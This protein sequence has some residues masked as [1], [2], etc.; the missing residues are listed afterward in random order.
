M[1]KFNDGIPPHVLHIHPDR[2]AAELIGQY[3]RKLRH[4]IVTDDDLVM[5]AMPRGLT[6]KRASHFPPLKGA[7]SPGRLQKI[8]RAMTPF[9]L[10]LSHGWDAMDAAMAHTLFKDAMQLPPLIHHEA[11]LGDAEEKRLSKRRTWYRRIALGKSSG[12]VIPSERLE[13]VALVD[14]QQPLGRVK[15]IAPGVDT[16]L[17]AKQPKPDGFRVIKRPGEFWLGTHVDHADAQ[18]LPMLVRTFSALDPDWHLVVLGEAADRAETEAAIDALE[19]NDRVHWAGTRAQP[20]KV[21]GLFD[22]FA[23]ARD[24]GRFPRAGVEAMAAGV[25]LV[26][27][28]EGELAHTVAEANHPYLFQKGDETALGEKLAS[29]ARDKTARANVGEANRAHAVARYDR[30]KTIAT[31]RRLYGSAMKIEL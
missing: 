28:D 26:V 25:A 10:V 22:I 14:W 3:G 17:F 21:M 9:D 30:N 19:L 7:P 29:L 4:T 15:R 2:D 13:E 12:L 8:A 23:V 20:E 27:P 6:L 1:S 18:D 5:Q 11:S 24:S 16:K 31:Y